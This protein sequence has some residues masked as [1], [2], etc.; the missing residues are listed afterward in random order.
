MSKTIFITGASRGLGRIWAEA[1]LKRGDNVIVAVRN[2][3]VMDEL[4]ETYPSNLLPLKVDVTNRDVCF[5][6]VNEAVEKFGHIE[7]INQ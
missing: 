4:L 7:Y 2:P 1:F 6:G 3:K 5:N